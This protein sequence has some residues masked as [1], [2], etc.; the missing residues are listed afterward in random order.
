MHEH[1]VPIAEVLVEVGQRQAADPDV[2][3]GHLF[4]LVY[5]SGRSDLES[6]MAEV[7]RRYLFGNALNPFRFPQLAALETEVVDEVA[8]LLNRRP[9]ER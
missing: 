4:G 2:H 9:G 8:A 6:L 1:G 7:S 5:P 3:A